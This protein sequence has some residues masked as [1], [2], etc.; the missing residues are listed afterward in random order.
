[1]ARVTINTTCS[2]RLFFLLG[3]IFLLPA[4]RA[5]IVFPPA[6]GNQTP[7]NQYRSELILTYE[8]DFEGDVSGINFLS[9]AVQVS[10]GSGLEI[11]GARSAR[12][13]GPITAMVFDA[14]ETFM[15]SN[16]IGQ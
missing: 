12:F 11:T 9:S 2:V 16:S 14:E 7:L 6:F 5:Q 15:E 13:F 1:M 8:Q 10:Q 3:I 4:A